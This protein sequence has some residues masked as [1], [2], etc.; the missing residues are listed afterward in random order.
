RSSSVR[1]AMHSPRSLNYAARCTHCTPG[2]PGSPSTPL[3]APIERQVRPWR[4]G[5][6]MFLAFGSLAL[7]IAAAGLY[8]V[9]AYGVAQRR[10]EIGMRI[11]L[12]ARAHAIVGMIVRPAVGLVLVGTTIGVAFALLRD[13]ASSRCCS[14]LPLA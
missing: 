7:L 11:A 13:P 5:A 14:T 4:L 2:S 1:V 3:R 10:M 8:S 12:G 6:T 9:I